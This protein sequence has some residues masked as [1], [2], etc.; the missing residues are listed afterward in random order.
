MDINQIELV[1]LHENYAKSVLN[2]LAVLERTEDQAGE[3][4]TYFRRCV[5]NLWAEHPEN[6]QYL[7]LYN[8][9]YT[10][11][12]APYT[13]TKLNAAL[14]QCRQQKILLPGVPEFF[15]QLIMFKAS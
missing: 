14:A 10:K 6:P 7:A 3:I 9:I 1:L 5:L 8:A 12:P 11:T 15:K 4:D 2:L 13:Q